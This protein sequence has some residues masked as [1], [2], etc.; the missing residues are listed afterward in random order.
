[1]GKTKIT[2]TGDSDKLVVLTNDSVDRVL[3]LLSE[4]PDEPAITENQAVENFLLRTGASIII[5]T[6][7]SSWIEQVSFSFANG[8][9]IEFLR[10]GDIIQSN[11]AKFSDFLDAMRTD[12]AG[13]FAWQFRR[14][15]R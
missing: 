5:D 10:D 6:P 1:M 8:G 3:Y 15:E 14:G 7:D 9:T 4:S 13:K 12:S 2:I 11:P